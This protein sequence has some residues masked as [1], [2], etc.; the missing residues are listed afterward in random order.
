MRRLL[1]CLAITVAAAACGCV[2]SA[3]GTIKNTGMSEVARTDRDFNNAPDN[4]QFVIV[5]DRTGGCRPG[6]IADVTRALADQQI[7]LSAI[8]QRDP[9][10]E[11]CR[12]VVTVVVITHLAREVSLRAA[13][14]AIERIPTVSRPPVA[15]RI[16]EER[17]EF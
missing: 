3:P 13:L 7:S 15:I 10:D 4:F 14:R 12:Q 11:T 2:S 6:V 17:E 8:T 9:H 5:A 1:Y 16:V